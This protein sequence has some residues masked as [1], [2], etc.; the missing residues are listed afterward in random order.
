MVWVTLLVWGGLSSC[1]V[2]MDYQVDAL[3]PAKI[4]LPQEQKN[5]GVI[6]RLDLNPKLEGIYGSS[7]GSFLADSLFYKHIVIAF[8]DVFIESP[9]FNVV[10]TKPERNLTGLTEKGSF[11]PIGLKVLNQ[12]CPDS[13]DFLIELSYAY[14]NDT[15]LPTSLPSDLNEYYYCLLTTCFWR[16]YVLESGGSVLYRAIDTLNLFPLEKPDSEVSDQLVEWFPALEHASKKS[17]E[18]FA[19]MLSPSWMPVKRYVFVSPWLKFGTAY[20]YL[21]QGDYQSAAEIWSEIANSRNRFFAAR[22]SYNMA[23]AC[24]LADQYDLA[25]EWIKSAK[26]NRIKARVDEYEQL[27]HERQKSKLILD[28]QMN[29]VEERE[30]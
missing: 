28:Q 7:P 5:V 12:I 3:V 9:R 19:R 6:S 16:Y 10:Q 14:L 13:T 21:V 22:A 30:L 2:L 24:E 20:K 4:F 8:E 1:S 29:L 26:G 23:L 15:V 25:L 27:L 11:S 17:G 18:K